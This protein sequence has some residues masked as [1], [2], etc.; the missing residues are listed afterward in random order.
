MKL[1]VNHR[2][3]RDGFQQVRLRQTK[4]VDDSQPRAKPTPA[5]LR[6]N[7]LTVQNIRDYLDSRLP[8]PAVDL[9]RT[10]CSFL[11]FLPMLTHGGAAYIAAEVQPS[12]QFVRLMVGT[13]PSVYSKTSTFSVPFSTNWQIVVNLF[14]NLAEGVTNFIGAQVTGTNNLISDISTNLLIWN[15]PGAPKSLQTVPMSLIFKS[16]TSLEVSRD[17]KNWGERFRLDDLSNGNMRLTQ[18]VVPDLPVLFFRAQRGLTPP[19]IPVTKQ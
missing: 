16:G 3:N 10:L 1:S 4:A 14:T 7:T 13:S 5:T 2:Q 15:V 19:P 9:V 6:D 17:F 12:V 8:F 11:V 18:R